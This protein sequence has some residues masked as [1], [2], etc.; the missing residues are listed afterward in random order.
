MTG[1]GRRLRVVAIAALV[2]TPVG[3]LAV[4]PACPE[5]D[6]PGL[7][8]LEKMSR[9]AQTL[10]YEGVVTIQR[11]EDMDVVQVSRNAGRDAINESLTR[12]TGPGEQV[13]RKAHPQA[14]VHPGSEMLQLGDALNRGQCGISQY[15]RLKVTDGDRVAGR[16]AVRIK[17]QP[18]D[19]Y[20]FGYVMDLD[21]ETGLLLTTKIMG[22][23][24]RLLEKSQFASLKYGP[25]TAEPSPVQSEQQAEQTCSDDASEAKAEH[26]PWSPG[27]LPNGFRMTEAVDR[28]SA[29]RSYTDG[30]SAFS[31]FVEELPR[32]IRPGEGVIRSGGTTSYTRGLRLGGRPVL[33]TV[34]GEVPVNTA[35]MVADSVNWEVARAD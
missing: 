14:C 30:L 8:W 27:W 34:I 10:N 5:S 29:R 31:V 16:R 7:K 3:A 24:D 11:G 28:T 6:V 20:R 2:F 21:R 18:R 12:L 19:M 32:D 13:V 33:I 17:V 23:G 1:F 4:P 35:R 25:P 26:G 15:Y 9:S 22:P